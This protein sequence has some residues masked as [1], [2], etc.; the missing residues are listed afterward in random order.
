NMLSDKAKNSEM[1]RIGHPTGII[2]VE[3]TATQEGDTTTITKLGVYR[4]AR[5]ILDGYVY[6]KNEVFED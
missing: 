6:V 3:S 1:I 2:P 4:T 5:P